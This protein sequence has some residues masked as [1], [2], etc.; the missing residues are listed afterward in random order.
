M[1][2]IRIGGGGK[3]MNVKISISHINGSD[4]VMMRLKNIFWKK[5]V[6]VIDAALKNFFIIINFSNFSILKSFQ[7]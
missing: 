2:I 5:N 4:L 3:N 1:I 7:A 6:V